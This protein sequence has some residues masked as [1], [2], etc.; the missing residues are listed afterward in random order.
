MAR[1]AVLPLHDSTDIEQTY[2]LEER[3]VAAEGE[4]KTRE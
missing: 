4:I 2:V 1:G 3:L